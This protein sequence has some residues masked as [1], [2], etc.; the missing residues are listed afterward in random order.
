MGEKKQ[1]CHF[2]GAAWFERQ[3]HIRTRTALTE[4]GSTASAKSQ[5]YKAEY[6]RQIRLF[7]AERAEVKKRK[8]EKYLARMEKR[9]VQIG[10]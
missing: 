6:K 5:E 8:H 7:R 10:A 4:R 3:V 9:Q 2:N 1:Q